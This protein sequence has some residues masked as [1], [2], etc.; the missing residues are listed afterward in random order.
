MNITPIATRKREAHPLLNTEQVAEMLGVKPSTVRIMRMQG[1]GPRFSKIS[2]AVRYRIEDVE[3]YIEGVT[4]A[5]T[6]EAKAA[7]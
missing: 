5:S 7:R 3:A 4:F 1:S 6:A 2:S